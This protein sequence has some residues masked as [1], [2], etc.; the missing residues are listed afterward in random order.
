MNA[1]ERVR[2]WVDGELGATE[3]SELQAEAARSPELARAIEDARTVAMRLR[4]AAAEASAP[5]PEDLVERAT[6]RAIRAR[7]EHDARPVPWWHWLVQPVTLRVRVWSLMGSAALVAVGLTVL[8]EQREAAFPRAVRTS[9]PAARVAAVPAAAERE[10]G[11]SEASDSERK[12]VPVRFVLPAEGAHEVAVAGDFNQWHAEH[13]ASLRDDD[14]DGVFVGTLR[15]PPGTYAYMFVV[16]GKRWVSDP[17]ATNVR[18]DGFG[19]Q[20]AILRID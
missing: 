10:A 14:G 2:R 17:Y 19:H 20:N 15:L 16:D 12:T 6:R 18:D 3:V 7:A 11:A 1:K 8:R 5:V 9:T 13:D 4:E